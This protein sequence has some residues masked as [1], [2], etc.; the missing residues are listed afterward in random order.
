MRLKI[1]ENQLFPG[2]VVII[3][4]ILILPRI[5]DH[6]VMTGSQSYDESISVEVT[7]LKNGGAR[8][9]PD[10]LVCFN[11]FTGDIRWKR[12]VSVKGDGFIRQVLA[13]S[14]DEQTE[15]V[16]GLGFDFEKKKPVVFLYSSENNRLIHH[17]IWMLDDNEKLNTEI[18]DALTGEIL[19]I[20][21]IFHSCALTSI[22]FG[23]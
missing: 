5:G 2:L 1:W 11:V 3:L 7:L 9:S 19:D 12:R 13:Q 15:M 23:K 17:Q 4:A 8:V 21:S 14:V 16:V 22:N 10:E 18:E 6:V 20:V